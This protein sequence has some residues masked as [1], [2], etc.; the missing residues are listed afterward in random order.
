MEDR[1]F[2]QEGPTPGST[3]VEYYGHT[4]VVGF[5]KLLS[6]LF[7]SQWKEIKQSAREGLARLQGRP[8]EGAIGTKNQGA[9]AATPARGPAVY[10]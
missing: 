6:P 2:V 9:E 10:V 5:G 1:Y 3:L 4:K 7:K 8:A